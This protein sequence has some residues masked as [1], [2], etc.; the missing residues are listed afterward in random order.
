M[1]N[2]K[3]GALQNL[4]YTFREGLHEVEYIAEIPILNSLQPVL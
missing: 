1:D 2:S 3:N 4:A